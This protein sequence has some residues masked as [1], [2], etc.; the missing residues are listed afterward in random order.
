MQ[1]SH[2]SYDMEHTTGSD[3]TETK[4]V[5]DFNSTAVH[6]AKADGAWFNICA[7]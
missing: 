2:N 3:W 7:K 4:C 6:V 5:V 1:P